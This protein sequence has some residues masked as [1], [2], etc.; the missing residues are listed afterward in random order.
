MTEPA[1]PLPPSPAGDGVLSLLAWL[2]PGPG[3]GAASFVA[4]IILDCTGPG[5]TH[6]QAALGVLGWRPAGSVHGPFAQVDTCAVTLGAY[7]RAE[8]HVPA[9]HGV[10]VDVLCNLDPVWIATAHM[11]GLVHVLAGDFRLATEPAGRREALV[12]AAVH[13]GLAV[14]AT[15]PVNKD[16]L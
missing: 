7:R 15:V 2:V 5:A 10:S 6:A 16:N 12:S 1:A 8:L 14:G 11:S 3:L 13:R 4:T 9:S